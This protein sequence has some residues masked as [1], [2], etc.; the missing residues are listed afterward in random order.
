LSQGRKHG[1]FEKKNSAKFVLLN[2]LPWSA[3]NPD[4]DAAPESPDTAAEEVGAT[5]DADVGK[6]PRLCDA[7]GTIP[8]TCPMAMCTP[9]WVDEVQSRKIIL[10]E[11][12]F[13]KLYSI[14]IW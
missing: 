12:E 1:N 3:L 8:V 13:R 11:I 5:R 7:W 4:A 9:M 10:E 2:M 6:G 14:I